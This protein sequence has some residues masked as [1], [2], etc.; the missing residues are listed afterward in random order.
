MSES[1]KDEITFKKQSDRWKTWVKVS[2]QKIKQDKKKET[3]MV[4]IL[5][6]REQQSLPLSNDWTKQCLFVRLSHLTDWLS[7][8]Y[9]ADDMIIIDAGDYVSLVVAGGRADGR[10]GH[11]DLRGWHEP[12][13]ARH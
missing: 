1:E 7:L 4:S 2:D 6:L 5:L 10:S 3:K 9:D 12:D 8:G 11:K 13:A